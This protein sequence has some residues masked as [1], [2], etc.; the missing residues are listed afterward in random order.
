MTNR[1]FL[2]S[3]DL[4]LCPMT[5]ANGQDW[6]CRISYHTRRPGYLAR[7]VFRDFLQVL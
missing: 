3:R 7:C 6:T 5:M 4:D 2:F 1:M